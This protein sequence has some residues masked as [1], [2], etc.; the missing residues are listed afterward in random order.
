MPLFSARATKRLRYSTNLQLVCTAGV[1]SSYVFAVNG[2]YDPDVT[3]TGHQPMGFDEMMLYYNHYT[4]LRA[5]VQVV[6]KAVS[7][8]KLTVCLRYDGAATPIT[9]IDRIVEL[10][11]SVIDYLEISTANGA[12]KRLQLALDIA[13]LQ[14]ISKSALTADS[15]LRGTVAANPTELT[16]VH[17]QV[18]DAAAQTG[19]V[20]FDV[21][22]NFTAV[23]YEPRDITSSLL[24]GVMAELRL[25][26]A[27]SFETD[28][29]SK[30]QLYPVCSC[31]PQPAQPRRVA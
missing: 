7:T 29:K 21:I 1:V 12:T 5:D 23:F 6:A 20:N 28:G 30:P 19:T 26:E 22:I 8:T 13:R 17:L 15:S 27:S 3:G 4:V 25:R 24:S 10:G 9:S 14:G 16:Y 31:R 18:W 11:A 2:L